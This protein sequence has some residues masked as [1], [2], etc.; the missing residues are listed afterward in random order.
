MESDRS[1]PEKALLLLHE[2]DDDFQQ[3][4]V[5]KDSRKSA[6]Y[7]IKLSQAFGKIDTLLKEE[8]DTTNLGTPQRAKIKYWYGKKVELSD[9]LYVLRHSFDSLLAVYA[10]FNGHA[11]E[12]TR[13]VSADL[14]KGKSHVTANTDTV[15]KAGQKR[16]LIKRLKDAFV[17]KDGNTVAEIRHNK[18]SKETDLLTQKI[19]TEN[20]IAYNKK[21]QALQ[22]Q[23]EKLLNTQR[24]LIITNTYIINELGGIINDIK[25][26]N[27][28]MADEFKSMALKTYKESTALLNK[29]YLTALFLVLVFATLLIVSIVYL[30]RSELQLRKE[31]ERSVAIAQQKMDLLHHMSHEIRNPLTAIKGFLYIFSKSNMSPKQVDMLESIKISSEMMLRTLN[32]TLDAAKMEN[33]EL[34]IH[35]EPFT[36]DFTL[37]MVIESMAFSATKKKLAMEYNFRGN[38]DAVVLGDSFRLKQIMVNLLSNAIKYTEVGSITVNAQLTPDSRLQVDVVDTGAGISLEQQSGLFS[39][40]Y[41]TSCSKGQV[42]TGLGLFICKQLVILQD[43]KISVKSNQEAGTTF[44]FYIPYQKSES[45]VIIK[46]DTNNPLS[47]LNGKSILAVDDNELNLMFLK[48]MT[49]KWNVIFLQAANGKEALDIIAKNEITV[50]LTDLQMPVMDGKKLLSSIK[51]LNEPLNHLPVIAISGAATEPIDEEKLLTLGFSGMIGKPFAE[52]ELIEQLTKVLK[53]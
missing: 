5:N 38:K 53:Q 45:T 20:K 39:Q 32:D 34:K 19:V 12:N 50:V 13:S 46:P 14:H 37:K 48:K 40:Y 18:S 43:G 27:Y 2:A 31:I 22:Q 41:Q 16:S 26:I 17:N 42:G 11:D 29:L 49:D 1:Q 35:A 7:K 10:D 24:Q 44:S 52:A 25:E 9:K 8:S 33:S 23:N 21:L 51:K 47:M 4:L 36:P 30:N 3:S 6:D 15:K 28:N